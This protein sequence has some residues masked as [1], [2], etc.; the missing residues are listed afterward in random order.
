[1]LVSSI[2]LSTNGLNEL[3][4]LK[5]G[6]DCAITR[7]DP[8]T[9]DDDDTKLLLG[10]SLTYAVSVFDFVIF[11]KDMKHHSFQKKN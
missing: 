9:P 11:T 7:T 6:E 1:M 10:C 5:N 3:T 4:S 2:G 8:M